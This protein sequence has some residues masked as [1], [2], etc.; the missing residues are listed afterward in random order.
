MPPVPTERA[1]CYCG[2]PFTDPE[3]DTFCSP[4]C[5]QAYCRWIDG[6]DSE[7]PHGKEE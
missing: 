6:E 2:E 5:S 3:E 7:G 4:A 1:C